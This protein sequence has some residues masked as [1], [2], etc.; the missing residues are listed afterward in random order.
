MNTTLNTF[1]TAQAQT[2]FLLTDKLERDYSRGFISEAEYKNSLREL[3]S[4]V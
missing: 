1:V 2:F 3:N 4:A